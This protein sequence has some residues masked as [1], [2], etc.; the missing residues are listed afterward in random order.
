VAHIIRRGEKASARLALG[1]F[2]ACSAASVSR[3]AAA[4]VSSL[5]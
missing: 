1:M 2:H 5:F 4:M 3:K